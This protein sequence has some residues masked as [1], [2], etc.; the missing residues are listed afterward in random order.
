MY[1]YS[2]LFSGKQDEDEIQDQPSAPK[3]SERWKW[4]SIIER[5]AKGDITKY[6]SGLRCHLY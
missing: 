3:F 5:L 6:R 4:F 1:N 2:A